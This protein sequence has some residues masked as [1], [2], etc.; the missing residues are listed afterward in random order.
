[1]IREKFQMFMNHK[2]NWSKSKC[3]HDE[4]S[5]IVLNYTES[6]SPEIL[7]KYGSRLLPSHIDCITHS[8]MLHK[9]CEY[10]INLLN[11]S[12]PSTPTT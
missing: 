6:H 2:P 5:K 3:N 10:S 7:V 9:S 1:M 4:S 11:L 12:I 8:V